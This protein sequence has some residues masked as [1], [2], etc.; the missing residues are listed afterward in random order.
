MPTLKLKDLPQS[1]L[2]ALSPQLRKA[3]RYVVDHPGEIA[4]RSQRFVAQASDLPAPT[5]TRLA[6][7]IGYDSYD[8]LRETCR[9]DVLQNRTVLAER[10]QRLVQADGAQPDFATKHAAATL[11]NTESFVANLNPSAFE[12]AAQTLACARRV[13]LIGM[14]S[15]RPV[16]DYAMYLANMSLPGWLVLGRGGY[17]LAGDLAELGAT[18]A[19][20]VFSIEPYAT[21]SVT[22]ARAVARQDVSLIALSDTALS[23]VG[24]HAQHQFAINTQ[25]QQFFPSHVAAMVFFE[26][27]VGRV[28]QIKGPEAQQRIAAVERQNHNLGEYWQDKPANNKRD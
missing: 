28:I 20:I 27:I 15:A 1:T 12:A 21:Q 26:A 22:L 24:E 11:L 4:T 10:A 14:M 6:H 17:G 9:D 8:A 7:A 19:A 2:L 25:S 18:D 16:V 23:P 13:A 5:F 3:A